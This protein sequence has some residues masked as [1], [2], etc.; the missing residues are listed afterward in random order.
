SA[1]GNGAGIPH[2]LSRVNARGFRPSSSILVRSYVR[3]LEGSCYFERLIEACYGTSVN[4]RT[5]VS[6][7]LLRESIRRIRIGGSE[8]LG[9]PILDHT[10]HIDLLSHLR[11]G[12]VG[13]FPVQNDREENVGLFDNMAGLRFECR[14]SRCCRLVLEVPAYILRALDFLF[15]YS[16]RIVYYM[17]LRVRKYA[18]ESR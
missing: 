15:E 5:N 9:D 3:S 4:Q 2:L 18:C 6:M 10:R 12:S 1:P 17:R 8:V 14:R 11:S 13:T 7:F 16:C